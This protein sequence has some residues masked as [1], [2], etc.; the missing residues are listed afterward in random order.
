MSETP[1]PPRKKP[2][3]ADYARYSSLAFQMI[4]LVGGSAWLGTWLDAKAGNSQPVI[5]IVLILLGIG[6]SL[7][8]LIKTATSN[9]NKNK[10]S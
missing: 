6:I 9:N 2:L 3:L 4:V 10:N 5:T 7:Y 1:K 8:S